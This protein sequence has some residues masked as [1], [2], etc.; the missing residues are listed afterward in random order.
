MGLGY[1]LILA[2][3]NFELAS[4]AIATARAALDALGR[5]GDKTSFTDLRSN[6]FLCKMCPYGVRDMVFEDLVSTCG[7]FNP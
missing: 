6:W 2:I 7:T 3:A 4:N 5:A 1:K